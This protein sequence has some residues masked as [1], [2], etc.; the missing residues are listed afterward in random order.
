M[1]NIVDPGSPCLPDLP[2]NWLS[3][4]LLS[5]LSV[6]IIKRPKSFLFY[7]VF[8][9]NLF[10]IYTIF[11]KIFISPNFIS[12]PLPAIFVA[13]VTAPIFPASAIILA[14]FSCCLAFKTLWIIF[15]SRNFEIFSDV[16]ACC[17]N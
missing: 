3:I 17:T 5:C 6:P 13:I 9:K 8:F 7:F 11:N 16:Y 2:L 14:S 10:I 1:K 4:L 15:S 12:V